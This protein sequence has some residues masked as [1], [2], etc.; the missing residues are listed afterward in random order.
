MALLRGAIFAAER[1]PRA[2]FVP[3]DDRPSTLLF[4]RQIA[5][6]GG[7]ALD[8]PPRAWL[9][10]F[11]HPGNADR[12]AAW[13]ETQRN[14]DH[15][16]VSSDMLCY[17]GLVASRNAATSLEEARVRLRALDAL[18]R[19]GR[20]IEVFGVI[21][22]LSLR[23]SDREAPFERTLAN[24]ATRPGSPP[25][26]DVPADVVK[27]YLAVRKRNRAILLQLVEMTARHRIDRLVIGQDDSAGS[28]YHQLDQQALR[29]AIAS[30]HLEDGR[31]LL[32]SG[33]D[34]IG[35]DMVSGWLAREYDYSP[36]V[37]VV[38]SD[39]SAADRIPPLESLPLRDTVASHV[40]L[41]GSHFA[42]A[43]EK[44]DVVVYLQTPL[45]HPYALPPPTQQTETRGFAA[46]VRRGVLD[47]QASALADVALI[48][49]A[50]PYLARALIQAV[51]LYRLQAYAAWNTPSNKIG[52]VL[53]QTAAHRLAARCG[54][55][56]GVERVLQSERTHQ[57]FLVARLVDDYR[58]QSLVR[59]QVRAEAAEFSGGSEDLL[60]AYG[61]VD[62][63]IRLQLIA[64]ARRLFD[65]RFRGQR[66]YLPAIRRWALLT[67]IRTEC[68]LPWQRL[69]EVELRVDMRVAAR[70]TRP[71][72]PPRR[73]LGPEPTPQEGPI[74]E[75]H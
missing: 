24:W 41:A 20:R 50:D 12:I 67:R 44:S 55:R 42:H 23:T 25:P 71:P 27:E 66:V 56:W 17:G 35:M 43:T 64:Y 9:G 36:A 1:P 68:T 51:P 53:A 73:N 32:M 39:P 19:P 5:R 38:Y 57:A 72:P 29:E 7:A 13:L 62:L 46:S 15:A 74:Q 75:T 10:R 3:L 6:I 37:R 54:A 16:I 40:A 30:H 58:Y 34:E 31:V 8:V 61:P 49:M 69:F 33:A 11:L 4:V 59:G 63:D 48:N 21:P 18:R 2:I 52:T 28:G 47:G 14:C 65:R 60:N 26:S 70:A 45:P 22:R